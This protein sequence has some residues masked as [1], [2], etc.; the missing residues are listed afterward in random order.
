MCGLFDDLLP[1]FGAIA[2]GLIGGPWGAALGGAL[3]GFGDQYFQ[4]HNFGQSLFGGAVGGIGGY[5]GG[6]DLADSLFSNGATALGDLGGTA[7][8]NGASTLG[9][10]ESGAGGASLFGPMAGTGTAIG[11]ASSALGGTGLGIAGG[12]ALSGISQAGLGYAG[13]LGGGTAGT[14]LGGNTLGGE[15]ANLAGAMGGAANPTA[16]ANAT[17]PTANLGSFS[18]TPTGTSAIPGQGGALGGTGSPAQAMSIPG[19]TGAT[20][21]APSAVT[22]GLEGAQAPAADPNAMA[23]GAAMSP[24]S[25][26]GSLS[27]MYGPS[28]SGATVAPQ[29]VLGQQI[30]ATGAGFNNVQAGALGE[31]AKT[32]MDASDLTSMFNNAAPWMRLANAGYG[33]YQNYQQQQAQKAYMDQINNEFSPNSPYAQQM[34]Q[35]LARQDAAAGRN[36]QGGTRA[37]QLAAA[38]AQAHA[39]ALG[40]SNYYRA[41]SQPGGL[42]TIFNPLFANFSS[43]QGMQMLGQIG[44]AGFNGLSSLFGG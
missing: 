18:N 36:S 3:G 25:E 40:N 34:A 44:S 4:T 27:T 41:A 7:A 16:T 24:G 38:L 42:A 31:A 14:G 22:G 15:S 9:E 19:G 10:L 37:V 2:G 29:G 11:G 30:G 33:A 1:V 8:A 5:F 39:Q 43:P 32:G 35:T 12:D 28:T 23:A 21:A 26:S 6:A 17:A 20:P 13:A